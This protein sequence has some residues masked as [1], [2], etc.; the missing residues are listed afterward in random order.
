MCPG[1]L[2]EFYICKRRITKWNFNSFCG[3]V[4]RVASGEFHDLCLDTI[5][6][7]S[8]DITLGA[9]KILNV[10]CCASLW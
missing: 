1:G 2:R 9:Y 3:F 6:G 7:H 5:E 10:M 4:L 8:V